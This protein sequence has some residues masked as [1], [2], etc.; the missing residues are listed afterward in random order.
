MSVSMLTADGK[1]KHVQQYDPSGRKSNNEKRR[2]SNAELGSQPE[3]GRDPDN[4][5]TAWLQMLTLFSPGEHMLTFGSAWKWA[6][7]AFMA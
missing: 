5:S 1:L 7:I 3:R 2:R 6:S 4:D